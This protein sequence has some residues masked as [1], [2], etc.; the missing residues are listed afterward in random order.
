VSG[1]GR[2]LTAVL[3]EPL[4]HFLLLGAAIFALF[5]LV[6]D[7]TA[8]TPA[9]R[10]EVSEADVTRLAGQFEARWGR[11]PSAEESAALVDGFV[12]EEILVREARA[13]GL[14]RGD[15]A[16]RQRLAQKMQFFAE[17]GAEADAPSDADLQ[18]HMEA[19]RERFQRQAAVAFEQVFL[20]ADARAAAEALAALRGGRPPEAPGAPGR[21]P[22]A[23]PLAPESV[24]DGTF[25][26]GFF[27]RVAALE[28]GVWAGPV[29]SAFGLHAVRL[30]AFEPAELPPLEAIREMVARDWRAQR[31]AE[32]AEERFEALAARYVVIRP[33]GAQ[34]P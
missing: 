19:H 12:R 16:V 10:I 5:A 31:R 30:V 34:A 1:G 8:P 3:R 25:G 15:A 21:L 7:D 6:G 9:T 26:A 2:P 24:I 11:P 33:D 13:L 4:L 29:P 18:A 23:F 14:D 27:A 22:P 32:M 20:G 17:S 28:P